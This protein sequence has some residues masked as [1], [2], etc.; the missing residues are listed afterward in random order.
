MEL[1]KARNENPDRSVRLDA[2][3]CALAHCS[4]SVPT[5]D[6]HYEELQALEAAGAIIKRQISQPLN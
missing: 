4:A 1:E 3:A 6:K 2:A 5:T